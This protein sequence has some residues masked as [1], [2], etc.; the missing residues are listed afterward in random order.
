M[1]IEEIPFSETKGYVKRVM[2]SMNVYGAKYNE[3]YFKKNR[4][5]LSVKTSSDV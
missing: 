4:F 1:F 3:D 2:R 5:S